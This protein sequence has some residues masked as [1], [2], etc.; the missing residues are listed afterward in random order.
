MQL[1][2]YIPVYVCY[3]LFMLDIRYF[4]LIDRSNIE[5]SKAALWFKSNKLI[6]NVKIKVHHV[7]KEK[8]ENVF[9]LTRC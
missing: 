2:F 1:N 5:L 4:Y 8:H 3:L 6:L 9:H 7:K